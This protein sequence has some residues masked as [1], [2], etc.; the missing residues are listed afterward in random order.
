MG[1]FASEQEKCFAFSFVYL[2]RATLAKWPHVGPSITGS[3]INAKLTAKGEE[4]GFKK[5][6]CCLRIEKLS[7]LMVTTVFSFILFFEKVLWRD[8]VREKSHE[9]AD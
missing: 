7:P 5:N 6:Y 9:Q 2:T 1:L 4:R 8:A 3:A